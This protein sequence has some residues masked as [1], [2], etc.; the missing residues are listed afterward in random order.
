MKLIRLP[1]LRRYLDYI[2]LDMV[3]KRLAAQLDHLQEQEEA[4]FLDLG[5]HVGYNTERVAQVIRPKLCLGLEFIAVSIQKAA[6]RGIQAVQ[7]DLNQPLPLKSNFV[8]VITAFDVLEH[9]VETWTSV[10]EIYRVLKP[11]GIVLIDCPNLAAWH[12]VFS[13]VLGLQ[14]TSGPHLISIIDSDLNLIE[15]MHRRDHN[16]EMDNCQ[17]DML[18]ASKMH[19]H[20]VIPTYRSLR[21]ILLK[22]GFE[23]EGSWGFGYHPFPPLISDWLCKVDLAHAHHYLIKARKPISNVK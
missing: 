12:N 22:A 5:C 1:F 16:I 23:I 19:R 6:E 20:I 4:I 18:S 21:R 11:G 8:D 10:T 14:P 13:L 7:H 3:N 15:Y 9:L 17:A 2:Y